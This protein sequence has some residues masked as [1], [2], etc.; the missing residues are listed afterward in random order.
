[1]RGRGESEG[2]R[3]RT[4]IAGKTKR[5]FRKR[6]PSTQQSGSLRDLQAH[7]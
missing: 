1:M 6:E 4:E 5:R 2:G 7:P 3:E